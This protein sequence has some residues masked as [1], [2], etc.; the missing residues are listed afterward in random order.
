MVKKGFIPIFKGS[1]P[2][3]RRQTLNESLQ[4]HTV[5]S[6][7]ATEWSPE[8]SVHPSSRVWGTDVCFLSW[9]GKKK[10]ERE[11]ERKRKE[12]GK[13]SEG[14]EALRNRQTLALEVRIMEL[15]V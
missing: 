10:R 14:R 3:Q 1:Q 9:D 2:M 15:L 5:S 7:A 6:L 4:Y 8:N 11:R 13:R 12:G